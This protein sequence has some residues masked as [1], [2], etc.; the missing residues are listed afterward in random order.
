M[1]ETPPDDATP[2]D[3]THNKDTIYF[4]ALF[5]VL[6]VAA[7]LKTIQRHVRVPYTLVV[8]LISLAGSAAMSLLARNPQSQFYYKYIGVHAIVIFM[9]AFVVHTTQGINNYIF[10]R[11]HIEIMVFCMGTFGITLFIAYVFVDARI[12]DGSWSFRDIFMFGVYM[13]CVERLPMTDELFEEGRYPVMATMVQSEALF[14]AGVTSAII[15]Y[16]RSNEGSGYDRMLMFPLHNQGTAAFVAFSLGK[17]TV[18]VLEALSAISGDSAIAAIVCG[19]YFTYFL[20]EKLDCSG[21]TGVVVYTMAVNSHRFV[22]CT[23][24]IHSLEEYWNIL[25]DVTGT[26]ASSVAASY[27][28]YLLIQYAATLDWAVLFVCYLL[29]ISIRCVAVAL[30]YPVI[31]HFGYQV[32]VRQATVLAWAGIKGTF[33]ASIATVQYLRREDTNTE[34]VT[35]SYLYV[36]GDMVLTQLVNVTFLPMVLQS[37]G[38]LDVSDV[39]LRTM[40]D[41]VQYLS[42]AAESARVL[43]KKDDFFLLADWKW[44]T[45]HT[46]IKNPLEATFRFNSSMRTGCVVRFRRI[47]KQVNSMA[48]ENVLRIE[49]VSYARQYRQGIIQQRTKMTL[50]AALQYPFDKKVYLDMDIIGSI[51]TIPKYVIWLKENIGSVPEQEVIEDSYSASEAMARPLRERVM[52]LFEHSYYEVVTTSSTLAVVFALAGLV[53]MVILTTRSNAFIAAITVEA[54][55]LTMFTTEVTVMISAYGQRF[56]N[57]DNYNRLDLVLVATCMFIFTVQCALFLMQ[58]N[59]LANSILII[60]FI[61]AIS[62]RF[63]HALKYAERLLE[64]TFEAIHRYLDSKIYDA[65]EISH[66]IVTGEEE[67]QQNAWKFVNAEL[68]IDIRERA[69]TNRLLV[70]RKV[71]EIQSRFPGIMVAFRS[72]Q[73]STTILNDLNKSVQEQQ[74]DGMLDV[75]AAQELRM[76]LKEHHMRV[77][78]G[79]CSLPTSYKPIAMLRVIPWIGSDSVRQFLAIQIRPVT[80][81]PKDVIV[82]RGDPTHILLTYSGILKIDGNF[83]NPQDGSLPNSASTLFFY[84][85]GP[86]VDYMSAPACLGV[87]GLVTEQP[88]ITRVVAETPINAYV[89]PRD[90]VMEAIDIFT[91]PPSFLYQIWYYIARMIGSMVLRS[92]PKYQTWPLDKINRR[93]ESFLLPDLERCSKFRLTGDIEDAILIHG[94]AVDPESQDYFI[95]PMYL[96]PHATKVTFPFHRDRLRPVLLIIASKSYKLPADVDWLQSKVDDDKQ[97]EYEDRFTLERGD[98]LTER[99]ASDRPSVDAR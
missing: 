36:I 51:L 15:N 83:E 54:L 7:L 45:R 44:V 22:A 34:N 66:A 52:D 67:V 78:G 8:F 2:D 43:Y 79:P 17:V 58:Q 10:R 4:L 75:E 69:T 14:N 48:V 63:V 18:R 57:M 27:T 60:L 77:I 55:Y 99:I 68:I 9:P 65:Y 98:E 11:C 88:S 5:S 90:R 31:G 61:G 95:A 41:A 23:D 72:R 59:D 97:T 71:V 64:R 56:V 92:H 73:A 70:L 81:S 33:L 37:L 53:R 39:E 84:N 3:A 42:E 13:S 93:L 91:R 30:L 25:Y 94:V 20:L 29:R 46:L 24:L 87:L 80:F 35:K 19:T 26:L 6:T 28:A 85:E 40:R 62:V 50:I 76:A 38:V 47:P 82:E 16:Y 1:S 89:V 74:T 32:T 49:Q 86:F 96:P 21:V 12:A